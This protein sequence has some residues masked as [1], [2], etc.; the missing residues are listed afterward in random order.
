MHI[1][2][3]SL[4]SHNVINVSQSPRPSSPVIDEVFM[5]PDAGESKGVGTPV[6]PQQV[7]RIVLSET[8]FQDSPQ[9]D[10][11]SRTFSAKFAQGLCGRGAKWSDL[12]LL[13]NPWVEVRQVNTM[14]DFFIIACGN[15]QRAIPERDANPVL[16]WD[17]D[18][19]VHSVPSYYDTFQAFQRHDGIILPLSF[20]QETISSVT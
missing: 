10:R 7:S 5:S 1:S 18:V 17:D 9:V 13:N 6:P 12:H 8:L 4:D 14:L 15:E 11:S 3:V 20:H 19:S 2:P 16:T